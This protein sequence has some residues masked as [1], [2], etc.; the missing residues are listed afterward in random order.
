MRTVA[1]TQQHKATAQNRCKVGPSPG[2]VC[3]KPE[4][5]SKIKAQ[6]S[7]ARPSEHTH[8]L[9][10]EVMRFVRDGWAAACAA[11]TMAAD[12]RQYRAAVSAQ[13]SVLQRDQCSCSSSAP[14][15]GTVP[16]ICAMSSLFIST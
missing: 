11:G 13:F 2:T 1:C 16:L 10:E 15:T 12:E 7:F 4:G 5:M 6:G 3:S 14:R 8:H 9:R